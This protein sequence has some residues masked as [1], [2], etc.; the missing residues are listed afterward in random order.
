MSDF[1]FYQEKKKKKLK[2][3]TMLIVI[4]RVYLLCEF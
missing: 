1:L 2:I 4:T 3:L